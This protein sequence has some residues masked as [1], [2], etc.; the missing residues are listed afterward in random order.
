MGRSGTSTVTVQLLDDTEYKCDIDRHT[1]GESLFN[2][3]CEHLSIEEKEF[4]GLRYID[5]K[6][7]QYNWLDGLRTVKKQMKHSGSLH[8]YFAVK[9]YPPNPV[10]LAEDITRYM[11]SLQLREDLLKGRLQCSIPIHALLGSFIA[12]AEL[13]DYDPLEHDSDYLQEFKFCPKQP[14][15]MLH[16]VHEFHRKHFGMTPA[17][18]EVQY[19]DNIRKLP[20]YGVD[21]HQAWDAEGQAVTL[22]ISAWGVFVFHNNRLINK[23][24]WPKILT[25]AFKNKKFTLKIKPASENDDYSSL[26]IGFKLSSMRAA[27]RLWKVCVEH[28][29]FFR[30]AQ[31][32]LPPKNMSVIKLGS[33]FRY[34]GRTQHQSKHNDIV[35]LR[36]P[37]QFDR[38]TSKR[39]SSK[40]LDSNRV[41]RLLEEEA[42][43][44]ADARRQQEAEE[45]KRDI[46]KPID[47]APTGEAGMVEGDSK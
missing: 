25:V 40:V 28:H 6:D 19:L 15:E 43:K 9:F 33:K 23:F 11:F 45:E 18:A 27:K 10:A 47:T 32:D 42:R 36:E 46:E 7:G 44:D 38:V 41:S 4:F 34:S 21:L 13:G 29:S 26:T 37:P 8:F 31:A 3:V 1:K 20:L 12:Q 17:D 16:K 22:G 14:S 30:L 39:F 24:V 5:E 35:M 2:K